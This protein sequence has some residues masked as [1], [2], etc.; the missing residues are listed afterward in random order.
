MHA[1]RLGVIETEI[2]A[3]YEVE[4]EVESSDTPM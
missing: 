1:W 3:G 2:E 4:F